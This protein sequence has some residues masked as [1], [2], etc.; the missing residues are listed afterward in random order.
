MVTAEPAAGR[1]RR[2]VR[3]VAVAAI[4]VA[5]L[6]WWAWPTLARDDDAGL[7]VVSD[8]SLSAGRRPLELRAREEG[9]TVRWVDFDAS[10]CDDPSPLAE[11]VDGA[12]PD[13]V[14]LSA[15]VPLSCVGRLREAMGSRDVV[16]L[17]QPGGL[18]AGELDDAGFDTVDTARLVGTTDGFERR[19]CEWWEEC[20]ADGSIAVRDPSGDL[21][22]AGHER[23]A[24]MLVAA[25]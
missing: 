14:V 17:V 1:S 7:L 19:R 11:A 23:V 8:G 25:L 6:A 10:W 4:A 15:A 22:A 13:D 5:V 9:R 18:S 2:V 20:D 3:L 21:T 12:D 16:A 24:R